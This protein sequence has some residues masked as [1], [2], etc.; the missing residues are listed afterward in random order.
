MKRLWVAT[1]PPNPR[2]IKGRRMMLL[3]NASAAD[4]GFAK[5]AWVGGCAQ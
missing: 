4:E 1:A 3:P 2:H 5:L